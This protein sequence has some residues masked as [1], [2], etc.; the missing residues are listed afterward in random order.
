MHTL[1]K[2]ITVQAPINEVFNFFQRPE[3]LDLLTP[4]WLEFN[5]MTPQPLAMH[6]GAVFDYSIK[7]HGIPMRWTGIIAD[8]DPPHRFVDL[9]LRGP[10]AFWHHQH[11]FEETQDGTQI[12]D[13]VHYQ[14][15]LGP[16]GKFAHRLFVHRDLEK[17]FNYRCEKMNTRFR[18]ESKTPTNDVRAA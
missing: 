8:Y 15:P 13:L 18:P 5:I 17:I 11:L 14:L 4:P 16:L 12:T 10:Y 2:Q 3:N 9:Q 7:N 1:K 6:P